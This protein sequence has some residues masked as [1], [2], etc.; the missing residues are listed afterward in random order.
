MIDLKD[1]FKIDEAP[2]F[3]LIKSLTTKIVSDFE[4]VIKT[5]FDSSDINVSIAERNEEL[6]EGCFTSDALNGIGCIE[7]DIILVNR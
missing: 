1:L 6:N 4:Q 5:G 2:Q 3:F 7:C